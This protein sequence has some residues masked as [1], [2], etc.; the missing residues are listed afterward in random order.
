MSGTD[1]I[2]VGSAAPDFALDAHDGTRRRLR[3]ELARRN[4]LL[5]FYP[6]NNTPG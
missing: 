1:L 6:G 5:V 2:T 4:V 3:D